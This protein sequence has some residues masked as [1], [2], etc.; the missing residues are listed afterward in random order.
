MDRTNQR[1]TINAVYA[2][3]DAPEA[4]TRAVADAV[5]DLAGFLGAKEIVYTRRVPATWKNKF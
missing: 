1:L 3:R 4:A 5:E 2:E